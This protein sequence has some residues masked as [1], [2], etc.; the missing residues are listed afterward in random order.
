MFGCI[1]E[2][3]VISVQKSYNPA[4]YNEVLPSQEV[5]LHYIYI[6]ITLHNINTFTIYSQCP[7]K[8][9][10][11]DKLAFHKAKKYASNALIFIQNTTSYFVASLKTGAESVK[12]T[13]DNYINSHINPLDRE[14]NHIFSR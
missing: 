9:S 5:L 12:S 6:F 11:S 2:D 4:K 13:E 7:L 8:A 14:F 1:M 3:S 10:I